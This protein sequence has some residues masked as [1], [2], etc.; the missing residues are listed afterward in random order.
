MI[1]MFKLCGLLGRKNRDIENLIVD[2]KININTNSV[3][4]ENNKFEMKDKIDL[5]N[6]DKEEDE[7]NDMDKDNKINLPEDN[8]PI[9]RE[10]LTEK[11]E[12]Q[13]QNE[14]I[15]NKEDEN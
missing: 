9:V 1:E 4:D 12:L 14:I 15:E 8:F 10:T 11:Q 5:N 3:I 2:E 7:K 6:E 13:K